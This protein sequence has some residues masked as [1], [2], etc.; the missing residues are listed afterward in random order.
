MLDF[1]CRAIRYERHDWPIV[2][3]RGTFVTISRLDTMCCESL[4][5]NTIRC[6][7]LRSG[8]DVS[9]SGATIIT[10]LS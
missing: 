7:R 3:D 4:R 5:S 10:S 9:R 8:H 2:A 1:H 6:D